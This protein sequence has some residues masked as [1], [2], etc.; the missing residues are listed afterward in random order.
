MIR[1]APIF[2]GE[3]VLDPSRRQEG[4][5]LYQAG[6]FVELPG[7]EIPVVVDHGDKRIG[8]VRQIFRHA[9]VG[10]DWHAALVDL[11]DPLP[12]WL[13]VGTGASFSYIPL[14]RTEHNGCERVLRAV[15]RELTLTSPTH[16]PREPAA[17]VLTIQRTETKR[18]A[19]EE[20]IEPMVIRRAAPTHQEDEEIIEL[21]RRLDWHETHRTGV[22]FE[23][24]LEGMQRELRPSQVLGVR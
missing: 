15:I 3:L 2:S 4:R 18:K 12:S 14:S 24:V 16:E 21:R 7:K 13:R 17:R 11:T 22:S 23:A 8:L 9:D 20:I 5:V 6:A 1:F 10:V 19:R